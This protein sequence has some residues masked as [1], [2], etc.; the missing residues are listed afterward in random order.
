VVGGG[1]IGLATAWLAA[2]RGLRVTV[3]DPEPGRGASWVAAGMLAPASEAHFGEEA[4]TALLLAGAAT[5]ADFARQ[6]TEAT[7]MDLG[8]RQSGTVTVALDRSDRLVVD[9]LLAFQQSIGLAARRWSA[10]ECR[11]AVPA[12]SPA[13]GGGAE[14]PD[15]HQVDNRRLVEALVSAA[16]AAGV[17][18]RRTRA[19][20]VTRDA[21]GRA[22]GLA[23]EDGEVLGAGT[24]LVA[25]GCE[26]PLLGGLPAGTLP[27]V[28]PVKGHVL[29][30]RDH[31][32]QPLLSRTVR[33]LVRGRSCYVV[34]RAD[35]SV[36]I[37]ATVEERGFD[38]TVQAG[39]VHALLEDARAILPGVDEL[40]LVECIAGLRPGSPDNGPFVGW[41]DVPGLCVATGHYRNGILL[42]P[43]TAQAVTALLVGEA[44][45]AALVP[46]DGRRHGAPSASE[47]TG[48]RA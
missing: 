2:G 28:R 18:V 32:R 9:Q 24:V 25:A 34:P 23:L 22:R 46:F 1:A 20:A 44:P 27:P 39:A 42:T 5:W 47:G 29:R 38:K 11:Q 45:P 10:T 13:I 40:E 41:T 17:Q 36:V 33:G 19:R 16:D 35:G 43:V 4:L 8:Y 26:T 7:G 37:G 15:D 12:L 48:G 14:F 3:V 30:L 31:G 21:T 6:L